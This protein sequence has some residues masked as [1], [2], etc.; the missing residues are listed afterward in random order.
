METPFQ[1]SRR[2]LL[3]MAGAAAA[4]SCIARPA[5]AR[6]APGFVGIEGW[7]NSEPLSMSGLR[8]RPVLVTFWARSCINCIH[9]MPFIK[10]WYAKYSGRG[11]VVVGVHTPEFAVETSRPAL[12][13]AVARFGL[14]YPIAQD[15][16]SKTWEA[17]GNQFWP[18]EYLVDQNGTIVH[19][20]AGEGG[21][22]ETEHLIERLL[23]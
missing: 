5:A 10:S 14:A 19:S 15:N 1:P 4:A 22:A 17:W 6:S 11:F 16:A 13:A 23:G 7:I 12:E 18:A 3:T 20:H 8:G 9:A 2:S 21:Y